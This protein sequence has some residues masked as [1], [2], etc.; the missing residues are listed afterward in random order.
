[1]TKTHLTFEDLQEYIKTADRDEGGMHYLT[2]NSP[3]QKYPIYPVYALHIYEG[4]RQVNL[5]SQ[6]DN[7]LPVSIA[8]FVFDGDE[9]AI[10]RVNSGV[11]DY[12]NPLRV[13]VTT[14]IDTPMGAREQSPEVL[15]WVRHLGPMGGAIKEVF[16]DLLWPVVIA[17]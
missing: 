17:Q 9:V 11:A 13:P 14:P 1:M 10:S 5:M 6:V 2:K 3:E 12:D 8:N 4:R 16:R 7:A 15:M